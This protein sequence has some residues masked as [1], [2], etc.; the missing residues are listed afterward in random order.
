MKK[1]I[2]ILNSYNLGIGE[3]IIL[4]EYLEI[5]QTQD[6]H[7]I[8]SI[9]EQEPHQYGYRGDKYLWVELKS[10]FIN[11]PVPEN[12]ERFVES[13]FDAIKALTDHSII[14]GKSF[15]FKKYDH[16][17]MSGGTICSEYWLN[18]LIPLLIGRYR[19]LKEVTPK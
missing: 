11:T 13:L 18:N 3:K 15:H 9:F 12:E 1:N 5:L 16:G 14:E 17:G 2:T 19:K 8:S 10:Y 7:C 4:D 6:N